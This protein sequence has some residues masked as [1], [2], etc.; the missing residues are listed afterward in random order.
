MQSAIEAWKKRMEDFQKAY[1]ERMSADT[2]QRAIDKATG[3]IRSMAAGMGEA[4]DVAGAKGG[5]GP[6][7]G[8]ASDITLGREKDLD[9]LM[10]GGQTGMSTLYN[11]NPYSTAANLGLAQQR[12]GLEAYLGQGQLDVEKAKAQAQMYGSPWQWYQMLMGSF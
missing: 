5:R 9:A 12:L 8:A 4:A 1:D 11:M 6:G 10:L 3:G 2:T 7:F